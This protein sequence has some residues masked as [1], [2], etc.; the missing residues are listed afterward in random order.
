MDVTLNT[1]DK[2]WVQLTPEGVAQLRKYWKGVHSMTPPSEREECIEE[3]VQEFY[4]GEVQRG[5]RVEVVFWDLMVIFGSVM[6][7]KE[8]FVGNKIWLTPKP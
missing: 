1:Y 7:S 8:V 2:V 3:S 6:T 4:G 5:G